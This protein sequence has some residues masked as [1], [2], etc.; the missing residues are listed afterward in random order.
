MTRKP[1]GKLLEAVVA[2]PPG[3]LQNLLD[4]GSERRFAPAVTG[5]RLGAERIA[6]V[7]ALEQRPG[8]GLIETRRHP[9]RAARSGREAR[10]GPRGRRRATW[11][12]V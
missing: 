5:R 4:V 8:G 7:G 11:Q 10:L 9:G 6:T 3:M 2:A 12:E 1:L